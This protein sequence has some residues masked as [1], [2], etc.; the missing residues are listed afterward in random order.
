MANLPPNNLDDFDGL[1]CEPDSRG[2]RRGARQHKLIGT[3][4]ADV[5]SGAAAWRRVKR[6]ARALPLT[7][8]VVALLGVIVV[9]A[10][11]EFADRQRVTQ[12]AGAHRGVA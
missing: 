5:H 10:V 3:I 11:S 7:R 12:R 4:G 1:E 2:T 9:V 8:E 6:A